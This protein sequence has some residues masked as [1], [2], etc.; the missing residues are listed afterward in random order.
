MKA[1]LRGGWALH[2]R[3]SQPI[4]RRVRAQTGNM[5]HPALF[6]A[7]EQ[8]AGRKADVDAHMGDLA[9]AGLGAVV[10]VKDDV[11]RTFGSADIAGAQAGVQHVAGF[12]DGGD[13]RVVDPA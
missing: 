6:K 13:Q 2:V 8:G 9:Q 1:P 12:S 3:C 10:H 5:V 4:Q 11:Q 7:G